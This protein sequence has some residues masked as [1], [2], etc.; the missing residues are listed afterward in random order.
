MAAE[1]P[2]IA[3]TQDQ[4]KSNK[5]IYSRENSPSTYLCIVWTKWAFS[6]NSPISPSQIWPTE[7]IQSFWQHLIL[8]LLIF[9][10]FAKG[11][12]MKHHLC[13]GHTA[14]IAKDTKD[15]VVQAWEPASFRLSIRLL[16]YR[17]PWL[18]NSSKTSLNPIQS[19]VLI[20]PGPRPLSVE[21]SFNKFFSLYS[22]RK[23][24]ILCFCSRYLERKMRADETL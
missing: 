9:K 21:L 2:G 6:I 18:R 23:V 19:L 16:T 15:G 1:L 24:L 22:C 5:T 11:S 10:I 20:T 3:T 17:R 8:E 13:M 14:F 7:F 12:I 4:V